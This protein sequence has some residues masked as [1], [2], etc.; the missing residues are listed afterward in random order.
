MAQGSKS[1]SHSEK[2]HLIDLKLALHKNQDPA[3][4]MA[5]SAAAATQEV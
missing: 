1:C 4:A 3:L 2:F 5:G